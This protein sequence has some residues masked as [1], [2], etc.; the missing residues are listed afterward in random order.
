MHVGFAINYL[1]NYS[2]QLSPTVVPGNTTVTSSIWNY[3][4]DGTWWEAYGSPVIPYVD[5]TPYPI[6]YTVEAYDLVASQPCIS[7]I[8]RIAVPVPYA[9]CAQLTADFGIAAVDG[10]TITFENLS[11]F[12]GGEIVYA[13]WTFGDG[14][15][16]ASPSATN[17]FGGPGPYEIC[18]TVIGGPPTNCVAS[19]CQW[20]YLGPGG[21]PCNELVSHGFETLTYNNLVGVLDTSRTSGM[22]TRIDWD[23]GDGAAGQGTVAV[24][25]YGAS[26]EFQLCGTLRVW[27]P[28]LADTC[29]TTLC[30]SVWPTVEVAVETIEAQEV[31]WAWPSPFTDMLNLRIPDGG[32]PVD[33]AVLDGVGRA[34]VRFA[35]P[36][37]AGTQSLDMSAL[38]PGCYTLML[39]TRTIKRMVRVVKQP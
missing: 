39:T 18:M 3:Y 13:Y 23:F 15:T 26:Q 27:G 8:C 10:N 12:P 31:T 11:Q 17:T 33:M 34:V 35:L 9:V 21:V 4:T 16:I 14:S 36:S 19:R 24:H 25:A 20:L 29:V 28:L 37:S 38:P 7:A 6:C 2:C 22:N 5:P 32:D 30:R 1:D